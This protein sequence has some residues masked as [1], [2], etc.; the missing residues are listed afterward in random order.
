MEPEEDD[1]EWFS[2]ASIEIDL[3][4]ISPEYL[5]QATP[6]KC[7]KRLYPDEKG[8]VVRIGWGI[9]IDE[10][11]SVP[12]Y[13]PLIVGSLSLVIF[14]FAVWY[15]SKHG[16]PANGWTIG[17]FILMNVTFMFNIWVLRTKDSKHP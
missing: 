17:S 3:G 2:S 8:K 10:D 6:K 14:V 4:S 16:P 5:I 13:V 15:T 11:F 1:T 9:L 7:G 12:W